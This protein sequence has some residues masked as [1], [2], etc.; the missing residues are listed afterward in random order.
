QRQVADEGIVVEACD[1]LVL[2]GTAYAVTAR[3]VRNLAAVRLI[4]HEDGVAYGDRGIGLVEDATPGRIPVAGAVH[5]VVSEDAAGN[6]QFPG[7]IVDARAVDRPTV[8][9]RQSG[10]G[11]F[12]FG[13]GDI[14][15]TAGVIATDGQVRRTKPLDIHV[16]VDDQLAA[17]QRDGLP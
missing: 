4:T 17:G 10:D 14:E 3:A 9:N 7:A 8:C 6:G 16:L 12:R 11:H 2:D 15:H 5:L 1:S 13:V